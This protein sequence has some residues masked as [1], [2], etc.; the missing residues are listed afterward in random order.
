MKNTLVA[1]ALLAVTGVAS[2][3]PSLSWAELS[4]ATMPPVGGADPN[5]G[6]NPDSGLVYGGTTETSFNAA[7]ISLGQLSASEGGQVT[8][9][10]LGT[11]AG[12]RNLFYSAT[13]YTP[14]SA[15]F[16][17]RNPGASTIGNQT[18]SWTGGGLLNFGFEGYVGSIALNNLPSSWAAGTSIGLIGR[19][20]SYGSQTFAY[21]IG[22][23]DSFHHADWDD[24]VVG[25]N[26][27][28]IPEPETYAMLLAGLGLMGFV[29]RRRKQGAAV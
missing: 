8:Y 11:E 12:Y 24:V 26:I 17:T 9:T 18:V 7:K 16:V 2:A 6:F 27:D 28:P 25:V 1:V 22:Y 20:V 13:P 5:N 15:E 29:A 10:Y 19:N 4:Q 23:N 14:L 21:V 3:A